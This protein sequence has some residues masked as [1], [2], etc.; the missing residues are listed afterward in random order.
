VLSQDGTAG[1]ASDF[2]LSYTGLSHTWAFS[3]NGAG[4]VRAS[5]DLRPDEWSAVTAVYDAPARQLRLYLDGALAARATAG[6]AAAMAGTGKLVIGRGRSG[7]APAAGWLGRVD[8]V[9]VYRGVLSDGSAQSDA[10]VW[11]DDRFPA[12]RIVSE[13]NHPRTGPDSPYAGQ[14]SVLFGQGGQR[15]VTTGAVPPGYHLERGLGFAATPGTPGTHPLY[16]CR[17]GAADW[18]LSSQADCEGQR[19]LGPAGAVYD[20][21]PAGV[22]SRPLYRCHRATGHTAAN[23]ADCGGSGWV[24]E[25]LLGYTLDRGVLVRYATPTVPA[26]DASDTGAVPGAYRV[27]GP[28]GMVG[29]AADPGTTPLLSC[30]RGTDRFLSLRTDCEGAT[31]LGVAGATWTADPGGATALYR[32]RDTTSGDLFATTDQTCAGQTPDADLGYLRTGTW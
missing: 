19:A 9:H 28:L 6:A 11:P 8:D 30:L 13:L 32:C 21:V 15:I 5:A 14:F 16:S 2:A 10:S 1:Y 7:T 20:A 26:E 4:T 31:A 25:S 3:V 27:T 22:A 23:V 12:N 17:A 18:F 29:S 24:T